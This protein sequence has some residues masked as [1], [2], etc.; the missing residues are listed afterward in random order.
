MTNTVAPAGAAP[1]APG[2]SH[3]ETRVLY[4]PTAFVPLHRQTLEQFGWTVVVQGGRLGTTSLLL[5]RLRTRPDPARPILE[6][7]AER[8]LARIAVLE[9]QPARLAGV[10]RIAGSSVAVLAVA[11]GGVLAVAGDPTLVPILVGAAVWI[12]AV[13][14]TPG[15]RSWWTERNQAELGR[16]YAAIDA[17]THPRDGR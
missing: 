9:Q 17:C 7:R 10:V 1:H 13:A 3:L 11:L 4:V 15:I 12:A 2:A 5:Q 14:A 16:E 8:A 6:R